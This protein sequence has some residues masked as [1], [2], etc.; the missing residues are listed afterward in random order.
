MKEALSWT[1]PWRNSKCVFESDAK[2]LV[3]AINGSGGR[4]YFHTIVDDCKELL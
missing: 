2:N 1:Q 3:D 4:S